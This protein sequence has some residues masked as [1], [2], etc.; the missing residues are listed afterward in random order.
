MALRII[1]PDASAPLVQGP[2][3]ILAGWGRLPT[4]LAIALRQQGRR[5]VALGVHDHADP[6]LADLCDEFAWIRLGAV[7]GAIRKFRR[8]GVRRA[9]MAGKVNKV[10][11]LRPRWWKR[12]RPD[13]KCLTAFSSQLFTRRKDG[14]DDTLL[15]TLVNV[16]AAAGIV[17]EPATDFAPE[18]LVKE[19]LVAG[20]P[21]SR[22]QLQDVRFGWQLAKQI[23]ALDVGQT[24]CV[25]KQ[26]VLAVEAVEGT[27]LCIQRAGELCRH[28]GFSVVKVA[29]P[30]QDMR[31]DVPTIGPQTLAS[32][33]H[34]GGD[35]LAVEADSTI[36]LEAK[37][38]HELAIQRRISVAAFRI[39]DRPAAA[40]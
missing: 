36:L 16:F 33:A 7:G 34:A 38:F 5:V 28:S 13:L 23:G 18:L 35:V 19:G 29:K 17:F 21:L 8:W 24:V 40:A 4:E 25:K 12:H 2:V 26:A 39:A 20:R 31:F 37:L 27:D 15:L 3:G 14:K 11:L 6:Q 10:E 32:I 9:V 30:N 1:R 22:K